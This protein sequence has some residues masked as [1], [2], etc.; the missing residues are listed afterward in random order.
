MDSTR[1]EMRLSS[2]TQNKR[3]EGDG[4]LEI[5]KQLSG[6]QINNNDR[7]SVPISPWEVTTVPFR[8]GNGIGLNAPGTPIAFTREQKQ[9]SAMQANPPR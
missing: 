4:S 3:K 5:T 1:P 9:S 7:D 8:F 2:T 6:L